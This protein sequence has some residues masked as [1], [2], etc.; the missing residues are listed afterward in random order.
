M[1]RETNTDSFVNL[2][3]SVFGIEKLRIDVQIRNTHLAKNGKEDLLTIELH[4]RI[5]DLEDWVDGKIANFVKEHPARHWFSR[6]KG[7]GRENIAKVVAIVDIEK[8]NSISGLWKFAGFH[9]VN[10]KAPKP[11]RGQKLEY[12]RKLR[13]MCWRLAATLLKAKGVFY[14]YYKEEKAKYSERFRNEGKKIVPT[15]QLPQK[16]NK[17]YEPEGTISKLHLHM[18]ALRKMI[19]LFLAC[20]WLVWREAKGLPT[21]SPYVIEKLGHEHFISPWQMVDREEKKERRSA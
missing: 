16:N 21:R 4:K 2:V 10:G 5:K 17:Y 20:L 18:M 3:D 7:V 8:A 13:T 15:K 12:S 19:K 6:V 9:V 11:E 1:E 14:N